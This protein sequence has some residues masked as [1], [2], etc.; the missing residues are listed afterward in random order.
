MDPTQVVRSD[1]SRLLLCWWCGV[2]G[3]GTGGGWRGGGERIREVD[4]DDEEI[5][6][7]SSWLLMV[8]LLLLLLLA[9]PAPAMVVVLL[10]LLPEESMLATLDHRGRANAPA[11][12]KYILRF[13]NCFCAFT[14]HNLHIPSLCCIYL[15]IKIYFLR[16]VKYYFKR[17]KLQIINPQSR[18]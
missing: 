1:C 9:L 4:V 13:Y 5:S 6:C 18:N 12:Y 8:L 15:F 7:C 14:L 17:T 11:S 16:F 3:G 10:L 2:A